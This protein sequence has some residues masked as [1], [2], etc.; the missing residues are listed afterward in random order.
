VEGKMDRHENES[1]YCSTSVRHYIARLYS[2]KN[3]GS[4]SNMLQATQARKPNNDI[5]I[6]NAATQLS[7]STA[8]IRNWVK[9][10]YLVPVA[11]GTI[12]TKSIS[13][14]IK[15]VAGTDKKCRRH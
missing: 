15:N 13:D 8:T 4:L 5:T 10:G 9:T 3:S 11:D 2:V 1:P 12:S 14:F 7:V 6:A